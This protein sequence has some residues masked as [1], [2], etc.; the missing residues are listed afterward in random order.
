MKTKTF[1]VGDRVFFENYDGS[2]GEAVVKDIMPAAH[3]DNGKITKYDMLYTGNMNCIEDYNCL[4]ESD[5]RVIEYKKSHP[6]IRIFQK[7]FEEFL[8]ENNFD[9]NQK[10]INDYL[11]SLI[12]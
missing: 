3:V 12:S 10:T 8:K 9:I 2:I 7:K 5:K 1:K 11:Y 6:D 4:S